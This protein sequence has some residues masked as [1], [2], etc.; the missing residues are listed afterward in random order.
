MYYIYWI[1]YNE[2]TDPYTQGYVGITNNIKKRFSYH[3]S[4]KSSDNPILLKAIEKGAILSVLNTVRDKNEALQIEEV[5]R[6]KEH[7]AWN[8]I[9]G[10]LSP[11]SQKGKKFLGINHGMR[12]KHHSSSTICLMSENR[13]KWFWWNNGKINMRAEKCPEG[14]K[15]GR[16]INYEYKISEKA[17]ENMGRP[18][19]VVE[20]PL[21]VFASIREASKRCGISEDQVRYRAKSLKYNK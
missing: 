4:K 8:I 11:P 2:H 13:K 1:H 12:N 10:G 6:P 17:K 5:Y 19:K 15:A 21:G 14:F 18:G 20:T 16:I 7:V 3:K 9:K